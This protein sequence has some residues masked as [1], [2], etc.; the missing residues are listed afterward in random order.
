MAESCRKILLVEDEKDIADPVLRGLAEEGFEVGWAGD[1]VTARRQLE[2]HWDL[3]LL[4]LMLPDMGG[5]ALLAYLKQRPNC[6]PVLILTAKGQLADKLA[7]FRQGCDDYLTKPYVFEEL[8]ER[9]RALLRR[10]PR[11]TTGLCAYGDL[12]LDPATHRLSS[13]NDSVELTPKEASICRLLLSSPGQIVSRQ[14]ILHSV[15]GLTEEPPSNVIGIHI[16]NL[17]KKLAQLGHEEWFQTVRSSG[18]TI[19]NPAQE[20]PKGP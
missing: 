1:G 10:A 19:H 11:M 4:D 16:F 15:W 18:F 8:L 9:V 3:V 7:L 6:P 5:E 12:T 2:K 13:G 17:R 14:E 20:S